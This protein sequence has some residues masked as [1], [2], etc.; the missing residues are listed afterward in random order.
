MPE[1]FQ[2]GGYKKA[3]FANQFRDRQ[4]EVTAR[5]QSTLPV[6]RHE[7]SNNEIVG[8]VV[9]DTLG[10]VTISDSIL[11]QVVF[12]NYK[13]RE[14]GVIDFHGAQR[15]YGREN[16][17]GINLSLD[18]TN[19]QYSQHTLYN[20][21]NKYNNVKS[22][23]AGNFIKELLAEKALPNSINST[24]SLSETLKELFESFFPEKNLLVQS[25]RQ[26]VVYHFL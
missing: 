17:Q 7:L 20:Y 5:V 1:A 19:Q 18:Q 25:Q 12:T 10:Q 15:H 26:M 9:I 6:L 13:P 8:K 22:E 23:M 11:L 14:I 2:W 21:N 16:V 3:L 24:N 4:P